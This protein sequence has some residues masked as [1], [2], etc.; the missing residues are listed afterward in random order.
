MAGRLPEKIAALAVMGFFVAP[1]IARAEEFVKYSEARSALES[2]SARTDS[3]SAEAL[4]P[5]DPELRQFDARSKKEFEHERIAGAKLPHDDA[6]YRD[7]ELFQQKIV[8]E[9]PNPTASLG[10][11]TVSLPKNVA[12]V[13]Y[14]NRNCGI[15]KTLKSQLEQLGFTNV[16]WLA[17]GIDD[18]RDKGYPIEKG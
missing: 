4:R 16:R 10:R 13:T 2:P 17:G 5:Q 6:Y 14:C 9:A 7:L 15:S 8:R 3:V 12:I 18:W 1:P 11:S